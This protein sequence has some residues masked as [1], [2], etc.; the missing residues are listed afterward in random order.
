[1]GGGVG[2]GGSA[3]AGG[4]HLARPGRLAQALPHHQQRAHNRAHH[5]VEEGVAH[6]A[7]HQAALAQV[8]LFE[9]L[10]LAHAAHGGLALGA[11]GF[12]KRLE[13]MLANQVGGGLAHGLHVQRAAVPGGEILQEERRRVA[14]HNAVAIL[15]LHRVKARGE[16]GA[17][18]HAA[19]AH[20]QVVPGQ[21]VQRAL[22]HA[23]V[24]HVFPHARVSLR[25]GRVAENALPREHFLQEQRARN[26]LTERMYAR[27]GPPGAHRG[28]GLARRPLAG[29]HR[30]QR[31]L[32]F[33]L[34]R[35]HALVLLLG[36]AAKPGAVVGQRHHQRVRRLRLGHHNAAAVR[37]T[38]PARFSLER[39]HAALRLNRRAATIRGGPLQI[40]Q[41]LGH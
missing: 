15:A 22:Q 32:Q 13:I 41:K 6:H 12:A 24:A 33:V 17:V 34:N 39:I 31:R 23:H 30:G 18:Q 37:V 16:L 8:L 1:M 35:A 27:V 29:K 9:Q 38:H 20:H 25:G 11:H 7:H 4:Q 14:H 28:D 40:I 3:V 10:N 36:K 19:L 2:A 21:R 5:G 26:H